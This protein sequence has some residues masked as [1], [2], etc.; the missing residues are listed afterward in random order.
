MPKLKR[1]IS[2]F[3][4]SII[5]F[6]IYSCAAENEDAV[7]P[8]YDGAINEEDL[9][10]SGMEFNFLINSTLYSSEEFILGYVQDSFFADLAKE[11]IKDVQEKYDIKIEINNIGSD[12]TT[13]IRQDIYSG[14]SLYEAVQDASTRIAPGVRSGFYT[15]L[16]TLSEYIDY[17]DSSKWGNTEQIKPLIWKGGIYGVVPSALPLQQFNSIEGIMVVNETMIKQ[18]NQT[19]PREFVE[20]REWTWEKFEELMPIYTHTNNVGETVYAYYSTIHW[21]FRAIQ[22]TNGTP[23]TYKDD[24][25]DWKLGVYS[26]NSRDAYERGFQWAF[27]EYSD[28]VYIE[29]GN[30]WTNLLPNFVDGISVTAIIQAT[31]IFGTS[32]SVA[33]MMED[34]G[35]LH[36]PVGPNG[37]YETPGTTYNEVSFCTSI[38][39]IC[40][41]PEMSAIILN[42]LY[43]YLP[44]YETTE[45][46]LEFFETNYF[47]DLRDAKNLLNAF[48]NAQ[49]E[50][51]NEGLTDIVININDSKTMSE[52]I[53]MY[54]T[55]Y[56]E[57]RQE[58]VL[59]IEPTIEELFN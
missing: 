59:N 16:T 19:D 18:L 12:V 35:I 31:Q 22:L 26:Q 30:A 7:V 38:P 25:G 42:A 49:Y 39:V 54:E 52:W 28:Y 43:D 56:E 34:F 53:E 1:T 24:D 5:L 36:M 4:L 45:A 51:R 10:F 11:R 50:Y 23:V 14:Q 20:N 48:Q 46:T 8:E 41:Y 44:G 15:D 21:L 57:Y 3:L 40:E 37:S 6:S 17:T 55:E 33:Y 29:P 13:V 2:L 47:Y 32:N 27:G 58:Y 9:S